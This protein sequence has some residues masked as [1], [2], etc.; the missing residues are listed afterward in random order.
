MSIC[1]GVGNK[2]RRVKRLYVGI[3]GKARKIKKAYIG[4]NG[5][6]RLFYKVETSHYNQ[7]VWGGTSGI[8]FYDTTSGT[9]ISS[10]TTPAPANVKFVL[11][12]PGEL[13]KASWSAY[14]RINP[15][16]GATLDSI[17]SGLP[18]AGNTNVIPYVGTASGE[19]I[20]SNAKGVLDPLTGSVKRSLATPSWISGGLAANY[21]EMY[22]SGS[23]K[24]EN[25]V[26]RCRERDG[27]TNASIR[28]FGGGYSGGSNCG[29]WANEERMVTLDENNS[30]SNHYCYVTSKDYATLSQI[31][32]IMTTKL[33]GYTSQ[34][35]NAMS[36]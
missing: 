12:I 26:H 24:H 31:A 20:C 35:C 9:K 17:T 22:V 1:I 11:T 8:A 15:D 16:T 21:C 10:L 33:S 34:M 29:A 23:D 7:F 4:V 25:D 36:Y 28:T 18:T 5:K 6:A 19:F 30:G 14:H 27:K 2:A 32:S 13:Y 3:N